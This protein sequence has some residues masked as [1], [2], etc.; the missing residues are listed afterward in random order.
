MNSSSSKHFYLFKGDW[1]EKFIEL[2][3]RQKRFTVL[4]P[5]DR[6][7]D[8]NLLIVFDAPLPEAY[9]LNNNIWR[10]DEKIFNS[11]YKDKIGQFNIH[12]SYNSA[13]ETEK[14]SSPVR[15]NQFSY[16]HS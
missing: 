13:T 14:A 2:S 7:K 5:Q 16:T 6:N 3:E 12:E 15:G 4:A 9:S 8:H 11:F 10:T 1:Y